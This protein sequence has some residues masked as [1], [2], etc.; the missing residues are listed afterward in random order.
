M[1]DDLEERIENLEAENRE[2]RALLNAQSKRV[3]RIIRLLIGSEREFGAMDEDM[4]VNFLDQLEDHDERLD[5]VERD[6]AT[7][8]AR[9]RTARSD[10]GETTKKEIA[11][12]KTRNELV[13]STVTNWNKSD[14]SGV[15]VSAVQ[16]MAKPQ[17]KLNYQTVKDAWDDLTME[18]GAIIVTDGEDGAKRAIIKHEALTRELVAVVEDDLGRDDLTKEL[19]SRRETGGGS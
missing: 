2:L 17:T 18:W 3:D 14:G 4:V 7:A 15:T 16:D 11:K 6:A 5:G 13:R 12:R 8:V 9:A 1:S 10:G 19:I